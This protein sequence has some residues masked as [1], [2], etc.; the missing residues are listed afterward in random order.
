MYLG[1]I[2]GFLYDAE[3]AIYRAEHSP[4]IKGIPDLNPG[5][6]FLVVLP[7]SQSAWERPNRNA[8]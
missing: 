1:S 7:S 3:D 4:S 2:P 8:G 6:A 5:L